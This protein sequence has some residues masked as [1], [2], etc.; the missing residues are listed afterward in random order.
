MG[1]ALLILPIFNVL[2]CTLW[3]VF[4]GE[5]SRNGVLKKIEECKVKGKT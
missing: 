4:F 3:L 2:V 1:L 5:E